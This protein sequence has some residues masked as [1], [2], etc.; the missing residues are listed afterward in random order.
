MYFRTHF[1]PF[2][3]LYQ[4]IGYDQLA[5]LIYIYDKQRT[6]KCLKQIWYLYI[7][8][9]LKSVLWDERRENTTPVRDKSMCWCVAAPVGSC[10]DVQASV[11]HHD[12]TWLL[13]VS[14]QIYPHSC[15]QEL[16]YIYEHETWEWSLHIR[17][18]SKRWFWEFCGIIR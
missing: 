4:A 7:N 17:Q 2:I 3:D 5:D 10:L 15:Q 6:F 1:D 14:A 16:C 13:L 11:V 18:W 8:L 9:T 12:P